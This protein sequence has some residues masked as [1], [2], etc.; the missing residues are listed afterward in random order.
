MKS[1]GLLVISE[2][3]SCPGYLCGFQKSSIFLVLLNILF[4][5]RIKHLKH[6]SFS[7]WASGSCYM[8]QP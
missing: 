4:S 5:Q 3:V 1:Y 2:Q 8:S 6:F 7:S